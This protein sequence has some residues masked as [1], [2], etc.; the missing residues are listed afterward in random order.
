MKHLLT[1]FLA[2]VLCT[3]AL[4]QQRYYFNRVV[5]L[6]TS[7]TFDVGDDNYVDL[8]SGCIN[9]HN[10][11]INRLDVIKI[12]TQKYEVVDGMQARIGKGRINRRKLVTFIIVID[13]FLVVE[14]ADHEG[15]MYIFNKVV[16]L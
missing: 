6:S 12:N 14:A 3:T 5:D 16:R 8:D 4:A 9:I 10:K 1:F 2:V 11:A 7:T 13:Q 15:F